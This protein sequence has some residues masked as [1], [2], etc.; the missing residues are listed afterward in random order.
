MAMNE[1]MVLRGKEESA[2][3][4][5]SGASGRI[6]A[7]FSVRALRAFLALLNA[8]VLVLLFPF[9]KGTLNLMSTRLTWKTT[10][11]ASTSTSTARRAL[12]IRRVLE[13]IDA[14][15]TRKTLREYR[16][17]T[18]SRGDT[19]FT[20]S[21]IPLCPNNNI[22]GLVFLMHGL[23]EHRFLFLSLSISLFLFIIT[24]TFTLLFTHNHYSLS[25]ADILILQSSSM[26]MVSRFTGWIGLVR[27]ITPSTILI[28]IPSH[29]S[30]SL[31][32]Y[33][34]S[35]P[36]NLPFCISHYPFL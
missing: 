35:F 17:L 34:S 14:D 4:L 11:T 3:M 7:L 12:A 10:A 13:D 26:P 16:V 6:C 32:F 22:K 27:L 25:V 18:T 33:A 19:I 21:W 29:C 8:V 20:Q 28:N 31:P 36:P 30:S 23:N 1:G 9:R 15:D 24:C 5:T 2:L